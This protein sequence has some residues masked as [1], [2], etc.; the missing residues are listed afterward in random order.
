PKG[1]LNMPVHSAGAL[2]YFIGEGC[3]ALPQKQGVGNIKFNAKKQVSMVLI[4]DE[5]LMDN[6]YSA[7]QAFLEDMLNEM[8]VVINYTAL[9][10][11]GTD[12]TPLGLFNNPGVV[13][14]PFNS[15]IN[16]AFPATVKGDIMKT[17]VPKMN[18]GGIWNG[19]LWSQFYNLTDGNGSFIY[20][21]EMN[22]NKLVGDPF[23]MFNDI[24]V[25]TT[26]NNVTDYFYGDWSE[27][28]VAEQSMF[29]VESSK[30]A[31]ITDS[32]GRNIN[33]FQ[34]G[35]TAIKVTSFY[36]FGIRHA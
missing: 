35:W 26:G 7:D 21:D 18:L 4:T 9:Y 29:N 19:V 20:R 25:G 13:K 33:L 28:M 23:Y 11:T 22:M 1:N 15:L 27:F 3:P 5:L 17:D 10:G 8:A 31:T 24:P 32:S 2:S 12:Y 14:T 16:V 36:D 6:S 34:N 30:E